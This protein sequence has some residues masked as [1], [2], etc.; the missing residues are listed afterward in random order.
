MV[1]K[2]FILSFILFLSAFIV[3]IKKIN[4]EQ[5]PLNQS[6]LAENIENNFDK[7]INQFFTSSWE[8]K[9]KN[10]N[11]IITRI[12]TTVFDTTKTIFYVCDSIVRIDNYYR[13]SKLINSVIYNLNKNEYYIIND[14]LKMYKYIKLPKKYFKNDTIIKTRVMK[15]IND[16][17]CFLW[18]IKKD[19]KIYSYWVTGSNYNFYNKT[20]SL[21][22]NKDKAISVF[23]SAKL[24][25][26]MPMLA[27]ERTNLR[28]LICQYK[29]T[30]I[31]PAII[32]NSIFEIPSNYKLIN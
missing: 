16:K 15:Y 20:C 17:K 31:E 30:N 2:I 24:K 29:I 22:Y 9:H 32:D 10:F 8:S 19:N 18:K 7:Q 26:V 13:N 3:D 12:K 4:N 14:N 5:L 1:Y 27:E 6:L 21:Y 28:E 25:G 11:G 23:A